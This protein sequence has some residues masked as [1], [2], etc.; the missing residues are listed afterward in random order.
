MGCVFS[1]VIRWMIVSSPKTFITPGPIEEYAPLQRAP[2]G[3][4]ITQYEKDA[5]ERVGLVKI[6]LLGNRALATVDE[7]RALLKGMAAPIMPRSPEQ[8][9]F[10]VDP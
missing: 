1:I 10:R 2:K 4:V 8:S 7:A 6:D 3:V 9:P 5:V